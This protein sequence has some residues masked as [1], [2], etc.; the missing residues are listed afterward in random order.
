M[1]ALSTDLQS[2]LGLLRDGSSAEAEKYREAVPWFFDDVR[3][4]MQ[5][6]PALA[7]EVRLVVR[8]RPTEANPS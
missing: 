4:H 8:F 3:K 7:A 6:T 5:L 1:A 2:F